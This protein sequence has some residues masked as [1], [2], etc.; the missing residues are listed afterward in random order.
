MFDHRFISINL[1]RDQM[2]IYLERFI[3]AFEERV[4]A[5]FMFKQFLL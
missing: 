5:I 1:N 3:T 2:Q 4:D